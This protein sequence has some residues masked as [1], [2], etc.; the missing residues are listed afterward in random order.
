MVGTTVESHRG[1]G[2][3]RVS[4]VIRGGVVVG[5]VAL[6]TASVLLDVA[7]VHYPTG[8]QAVVGTLGVLCG[9]IIGAR[10]PA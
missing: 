10:E 3:R 1:H 5:L 8:L 7:G 6:A 2:R 9:A 4:H